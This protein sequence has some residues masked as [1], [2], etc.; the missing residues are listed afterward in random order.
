MQ[1]YY[2]EEGKGYPLFIIHGLWG[3]SENW[4]PVAHLLSPFFRVILPDLR[5]HGQSPHHPVHTYTS[6]AEDIMELI[7]RLHL[8]APPHL[9]GHSMGGKTV[10]SLLLKNPAWTIPSVV[11]DIAPVCYSL[12]PQHKRLF[13]FLH[14]ADLSRFT[15]HK[16]LKTYLSFHFP[17]VED[18]Q[19]LLKNIRKKGKGYHW[20]INAEALYHNRYNLCAWPKDIEHLKYNSPLLFIKGENSPYISGPEALKKNFPAAL[21]SSLP[22]SGH[23]LHTEQPEKL[24]NMIL[25]YLK[26]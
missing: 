26:P 6:M 15:T 18:Q 11:L 2:R 9:I 16:E 24:T 7:Q 25:Q 10:M 22:G 5:N 20:K 8:P 23:W 12:S 19:I 4:L 1:L 17:A 3:A 14:T 21:L 13:D